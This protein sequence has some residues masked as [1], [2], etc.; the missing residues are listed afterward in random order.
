MNSGDQLGLRER[1][2]LKTRVTLRKV[3]YELFREKGYDNTTV[4]EIAAAA[5]VSQATFFRYFATK[6][7]LVIDDDYD[8]MF[9]AN[10][11]PIS[12][13]G[14]PAAQ[15]LRTAARLFSEL[16]AETRATE[17]ER[18][19]MT[20][21]SPVLRAALAVSMA[22]TAD[23]L[24]LS[25]AQTYDGET[26]ELAVRAMVGAIVGAVDQVSRAGEPLTAD[27][28][29]KLADLFERGLPIGRD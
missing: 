13:G 10:I 2:K 25:I 22:Q 18:G 14:N 15:I 19:Q 21:S 29:L 1:K 12:A 6:E 3:A 24:A 28:M 23:E 11:P 17:I 4:A 9:L 8:A 7:A 5:E 26:D 27:I 20:Q 16:D